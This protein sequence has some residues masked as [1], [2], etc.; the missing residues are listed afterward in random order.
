MPYLCKHC[1]KCFS[2][3]SVCK[4]H[5]RTH[6]G[7]KP[8][9]CKHCKKCFSNLGNCKKHERTHTGV[10][11]YTC[12][13]CKKCFSD[14]GNCKQHERTHTGVKPYTCKYCKKCFIRSSDCKRHERTHTG[15]KPYTCKHCK[16]C[17]S[18]LG[19][20]KRHELT[21]TGVKSY[22]CKYCKKCFSQSSDCK[23]HERTHTGEK[24][25]TCKH[26]KKCFSEFGNCKRHETTHTGEKPFTC[27]HCNKCFSQSSSCKRHEEKHTTDSSLKPNQHGPKLNLRRHL[28]EPTTTQDS[29]KSDML[30]TSTEENLSQVESLT[31][32]ICQ[33]EFSR[34]TCLMQ[35]YDDHMRSKWRSFIYLFIIFYLFIYLFVCLFIYYHFTVVCLV[36]WPLHGSEAGG[37]LVLAQSIYFFCYVKLVVLI[38]NSWNLNSKSRE[39][40]IKVRLPQASLG[41][42]ARDPFLESTK[43]FLHPESHSKI[44]NLMIKELFYLHILYVNKGFLHKRSSRLIYS[45]VYR[46]TKNGFA[47][48]KR[49]RGFLESDPRQL[50]TKY[51]RHTDPNGGYDQNEIKRNRALNYLKQHCLIFRFAIQT[52]LRGWVEK[53]ICEKKTILLQLKI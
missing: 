21:H 22:T 25:Y 8:Y 37:E 19:N 14:L 2:R 13:H 1:N 46:W 34:E 18:E 26:C 16:K 15:E 39:V 47:G 35:H 6:T 49:F 10:K 9:T 28:Q 53:E 17:F 40:C 4:E 3:S 20:C 42:I 32:W 50:F 43:K 38:L 41:F 30:F 5:E 44:S 48:P 51:R 29:I 23:I 33:E 27:Q 45:S 24:P 52:F 12:K 36:T 7:V 31:C 11:P